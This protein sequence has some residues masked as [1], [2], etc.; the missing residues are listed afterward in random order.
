MAPTPELVA[1]YRAERAKGSPAHVAL[2]VARYADRTPAHPWL[3]K[4][5]ETTDA[6]GM[7][8][9]LLV[10]VRV[11]PDEESRLG[12]DDVTGTFT[13]TADAW[14]IPNTV[15]PDWD[16]NGQG[17]KFYRPC[18]YTREHALAYHRQMGMSRQV[19]AETYAEQVRREMHDDAHRRWYGVIVTIAAAGHSLATESLWGIDTVPGYNGQPY[20]IET[21]ENLIGAAVE[22][23]H[24]ALPGVIATAQAAVVLRQSQVAELRDILYRLDRQ[25]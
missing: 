11:E 24:T 19:A 9:P 10:R 7:I 13:D 1:R 22:A 25:S 17:Y 8:G 20:F 18:T 12:D 6:T 3:A 14:T 21:A 16:V 23:A 5:D 15:R 4:L 2:S